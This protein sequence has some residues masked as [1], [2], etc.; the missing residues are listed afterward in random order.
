MDDFSITGW[1]IGGANIKAARINYNAAEGKIKSIKSSSRFFPMWN[2]EKDPLPV[3]EEI[4]L[5]LGK[6]S[7]Y[8]VTMTAELADRFESKIEGINYIINLFEKNYNDKEIYYYNNNG[9]AAEK[10]NIIDL[11][12]I[13]AANWAVSALFA[14]QFFDDFILFDIGSTSTDIIP[15]ISKKIA[16]EGFTDL[17][18]LHSGELIYLGYLRSS[19]S[20]LVKKIPYQGKMIDVINEYFANTADLHLLKGIINKNEYTIPTPNSGDKSKKAA[21]A[22]IARLISLDL[23]L[24]NL[25]EIELAADYI[26]QKEI[27]VIYE[28]LLQVYSRIDPELNLPLLANR[29]ALKFAED[30]KKK[31]SFNF[32]ALEDEIPILENNILSAAAAAFLL[33]KKVV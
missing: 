11:A 23:N 17:E 6:S 13:A 20:Y 30:L 8:G 33:I 7:I 29:G 16:A 4:N 31:S 10:E 15:V 1:D 3:L 21:A 25:K 2:K 19:L 14:A 22:R 32:I 28:K 18:R 26:Y 9:A 5:E 12:K 24:S 27:E